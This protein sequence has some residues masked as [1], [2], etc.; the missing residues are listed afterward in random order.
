MSSDKFTWWGVGRWLMFVGLPDSLMN[1]L[2][3][4]IGHH[5][6]DDSTD[7]AGAVLACCWGGGGVCV[8]MELAKVEGEGGRLQMIVV[9][10]SAETASR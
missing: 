10:W 5:T 1:C 9:L 6:W 2:L 4:Q 7:A 8:I 3:E